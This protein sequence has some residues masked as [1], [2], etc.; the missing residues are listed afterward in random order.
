MLSYL[1]SVSVS[2]VMKGTHGYLSVTEWPLMIVSSLD[3]HR[4]VIY[5]SVFYDG[6]LKWDLETTAGPQR[7]AR[8]LWK[9]LEKICG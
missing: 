8:G 5:L 6:F 7:S 3:S 9:S 4:F 1:N 2:A